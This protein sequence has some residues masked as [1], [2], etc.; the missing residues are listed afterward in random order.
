V[1]KGLR[2]VPQR[3]A[4]RPGLFRV[5]SEMI[6]IPLF[7][8]TRFM[9]ISWAA[10]INCSDRYIIHIRSVTKLQPCA[11]HGVIGRL[12]TISVNLLL[13]FTLRWLLGA[14]HCM[15]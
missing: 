12:R 14:V 6:G 15:D 5:E 13:F 4:S 2:E 11:P 8:I 3:F 1:C 7:E 9:T 10:L